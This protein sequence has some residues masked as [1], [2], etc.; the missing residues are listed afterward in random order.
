MRVYARPA[1][2]DIV[3][4]RRRFF[5][6]CA[7]VI[8]NIH[9]SVRLVSHQVHS[10][11]SCCRVRMSFAFVAQRHVNLGGYPTC[12][13]NVVCSMSVLMARV[14]AFLRYRDHRSIP[15][16][17]EHGEVMVLLQ[18][19]LTVLQTLLVER[20]RLANQ[21]L[22][23]GTSRQHAHYIHTPAGICVDTCFPSER[24]YYSFNVSCHPSF[25]DHRRI[26]RRSPGGV[27]ARIAR[28]RLDPHSDR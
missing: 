25:T 7:C 4:S 18:E 11:T 9:L 19:L 20:A 21:A 10:Q 15:N 26:C 28:S 12:G 5:W 24:A 2:N 8:G 27:L 3:C 23:V 16:P 13:L 17:G 6:R 14:L 22:A 1:S